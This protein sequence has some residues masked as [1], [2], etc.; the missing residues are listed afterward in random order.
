MLYKGTVT[1]LFLSRAELELGHSKHAAFKEMSAVCLGDCTVDRRAKLPASGLSVE[2]QVQCLIEQASDPNL[3][4]RTW[5]GW[6]PW[7]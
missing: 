5:L 7:M 3:L 2:Q 6:E 1:D 4:G